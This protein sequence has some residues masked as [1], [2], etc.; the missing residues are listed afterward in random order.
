MAA[1]S[2]INV[3]AVTSGKG[4]VGKT[5][6]SVNLAVSLAAQGRSV[7]LFDADLGLANVD[8]ALGLKPKYDIRHVISG[9]RTLEEILMDGPNGIRVVPA[10]SG[11][12][13]MTSLTSQQQAGLIRAFNELTF[14]V[15]VLIVDTGAGID[16][17]VLTFTS[18]CQEIIVVICDEPT[19]ITDA[20]ALIKVLNRECG[21]KRFQLLANM[22]ENDRQGR[23]LYDKVSRV[24]DRF[25]DVHLGYLGAIPWDEYLRKAVQQ[26][27]AVVQT[28]PRSPSAQ[29]LVKL[30]KAIDN[31]SSSPQSPGGL[32]FFVERLIHYGTLGI[33]V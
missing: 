33:E 32:G 13:S 19:S 7:V 22:V 20:Y 12:S 1:P 6:V 31:P 11:V 5:N 26:Q 30:A 21:V 17:S 3:I 14:P 2:S 29:A 25:L 18:A 8:I 9:E 28:Y 4:G 16:L 27:S 10:S 23:Q 24:A 15:D